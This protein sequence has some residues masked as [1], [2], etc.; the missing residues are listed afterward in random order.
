MGRVPMDSIK[1]SLDDAINQVPKNARIVFL[2]Q[3]YKTKNHTGKPVG[4][5]P[6]LKIEHTM[7]AAVS[8]SVVVRVVMTREDTELYQDAVKNSDIAANSDNNS[9]VL[10]RYI[11]GVVN[12]S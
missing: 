9:D 7:W 12:R 2:C 11:W 10:S 3:I 4:G 8:P 1:I 5:C 6:F